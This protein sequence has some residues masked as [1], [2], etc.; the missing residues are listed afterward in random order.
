MNSNAPPAPAP[1][2]GLFRPR[3]LE[4]RARW[5]D[6]GDLL[7]LDKRPIRWTYRILVAA[8]I[9]ALLFISFFEVH[10]YATG[11]AVVRVEGRRAV[12]ATH[13][14]TVETVSVAPGQ[15]VEAGA[16]L[17]RFYDAEER[18]LLQR[19]SSEFDLQIVRLLRDPN[20]ATAKAALTGLKTQRDLAASVVAERVLRAP[21]A[22]VVSDVRIRPGQRLQAG[23]P[24][25]AV[26]PDDAEV[27]LVMAIPG[28]SRPM[29]EQGASVRFSLDGYRYEYHDI[30]VEDV[31]REVVGVAEVRRF[32]GP[33]T[34]DTLRLGQ[35]GS[36]VLVR[37]KLP[38]RTFVSEGHS[39]G[40]FDGLTGTAEIRVRKESI[41]VL[42]LPALKGLSR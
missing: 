31:G 6:D 19:L 9:A 38:A 13:P 7:R 27:S 3:A 22:G 11:A 1:G 42:L 20:D 34:A 37:G 5:G 10:D 14:G 36:Y 18:A 15:R 21:V 24:V 26:A 32:L 29:I 23:E 12:T 25:L 8:A 33:E 17:V 28:E 40:Y 41:L 30:V 2:A 4:E 35:N 16:P 39:Y